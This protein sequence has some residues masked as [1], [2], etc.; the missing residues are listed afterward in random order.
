MADNSKITLAQLNTAI[1]RTKNYVD[2]TIDLELSTQY[3]A[4]PVEPLNIITYDGSN[5][6]THPCV[7]YFENGWNGYK[8]WMTYSPFPGNAN[9]YENPCIMFSDDGINWSDTGISNPI[10]NYPQEG[11]EK[12]GYNS[13]PHIV[14][15]NNTLECW[16]RTHYQSGANA[17]I[18]VI[19]R[20]KSTDG[21]NWSEKEELRRGTTDDIT[22]LVSPV[23][24]YD[25]GKYKIWV[26]YKQQCLKYYESTDGTNWTF[27]RDINMLVNDV[28]YKVW[29]IDIIK[30]NNKYEFVGCYRKGTDQNNFIYHAK[31][32]DN[33]KYT[34]PIKILGNGDS[35][36]F[37]DLE[38]YRPSLCID[39]LGNYRLY[40]G[41]QKNKAIWHIG[42]VTCRNIESLNN[43]LVGKNAVIERL[44]NLINT[45]QDE[46]NT[47]Y[48]L[49]ENTGGGTDVVRVDSVTLD[50]TSYT[51][52]E[53]ST[54]QLTAT[55]LPDN[56]TNKTVTWSANSENCT[57]SS[58]GLVTAKSVGE[59]TITC[60]SN[61][62]T[63]ATAVC[64][65]TVIADTGVV[66]NN[67]LDFEGNYNSTGYY[68]IDDGTFVE[69]T[70]F[71]TTGLIGVNPNTEILI[72]GYSAVFFD[73]SQRFI[74]SISPT[75]SFDKSAITPE[76][77][78]YIAIN[79][80]NSKYK[81][82]YLIEKPIIVNN[83]PL[84]EELATADNIDR[85]GFYNG[86]T[87]EFTNSL[88]YSCLKLFKVTGGMKFTI[89]N[90]NYLTYWNKNK[91]LIKGEDASGEKVIPYYA[92]YISISFSASS[93]LSVTRTE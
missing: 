16:W 78:K 82:M 34:I 56:A 6:P 22:Q 86:S 37:D 65:I 91:R 58:T 81:E 71:G 59:C 30:N 50:K 93:T 62:N 2:N 3:K 72:G 24:M 69:H 89:R 55:V 66:Y 9:I 64:T 74:S 23:V 18:E 84:N 60:T 35:G 57:I 79:M 90:G 27:I 33:I 48:T 73:E 46:I 20:K 8:Y 10:E 47:L 85:T 51:L 36:Q 63:S 21:I 31:S 70:Q 92:E 25:E 67:K 32:N 76:N 61:S 42:L 43:L 19:Y 7:R 5:Q 12:V 44:E 11:N 68:S 54:L 77:A 39:S 83:I 40:Y 28:Q 52:I 41:A 80:Q 29:H 13:D 75:S 53:G 1:T 88:Q 4:N 87:G 17:G 49:I 26:V 45:Q 15:V 14:L 38:L